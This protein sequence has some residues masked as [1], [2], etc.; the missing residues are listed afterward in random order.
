MPLHDGI[1]GMTVRE[2]AEAAE[3]GKISSREI[4][5]AFACRIRAAE[6]FV[7]AFITVT[8]DLA[9]RAAAEADV[10]PRGGMSALSRVPYAVKDNFA[11]A[12]VPMTCASRM[13]GG[14]VPGYTAE[15]C[16]RA[17]RIILGKT[18]L[19]EFAMG[20][21]CERSVYGPTRNPRDPLRT[22]GGSSGGSA[23]AVASFMAPWALAS[24]TGGSA[25]QPAAFC[26]LVSMK[27]TYGLVSRYGL[28]ELASSMD[29]VCPITRNVRDNAYVLSSIC[30]RDPKDMT[31]TDTPSDIMPEEAEKLSGKLR[32]GVVTS[33]S[34]SADPAAVKA[35]G[36]A[37]SIFE[38]NGV[39]VFEADGGIFENYDYAVSAYYI[40]NAAE[41]FS[42][43]SRYDG[44]RYGLRM[45]GNGAE[46]IA[47]SSR[48]A[49]FGDEVKRRIT[50]GAEALSTKPDGGYYRMITSA[51]ERIR[52]AFDGLFGTCDAVLLLTSENLPDML[53][54][55][56]AEMYLRD[57]YTCMANLAGIPAVTLPIGGKDGLP[58]GGTLMGR[59]FSEK[60]LYSAAALLEDELGQAVAEEVRP[61]E[62]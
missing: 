45:A 28:T 61:V 18:N 62:F 60:T 46:E 49:G 42:N 33:Y 24:D 47:A 8:D 16:T 13:L 59:K 52:E 55:D 10:I 31:S 51:R 12:G 7:N 39:S 22:A 27:P 26:S 15:A 11:V 3:G 54:G 32:I 9:A 14:Y 36:R 4:T 5:E 1:I 43:M 29:T 38:R 57:R 34:P 58:F 41:C 40:I 35:L 50:A 25:R 6:P 23:A 17:G 48:S 56:G 44:I 30:G 2:L 20:S 19:D 21:S 37:A 53:G